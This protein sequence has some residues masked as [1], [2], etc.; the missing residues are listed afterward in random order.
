MS[1][2]ATQTPPLTTGNDAAVEPPPYRNPADDLALITNAT[3]QGL[4]CSGN[5]AFAHLI[6]SNMRSAE[7]YTNLVR[8]YLRLAEYC[9]YVVKMHS[10]IRA[11][12][13]D[14]QLQ[15]YP[16]FWPFDPDRASAEEA[17]GLYEY[18]AV[19]RK[20]PG[21]QCSLTELPSR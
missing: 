20:S 8:A 3:S 14:R 2:A 1:D 15:G 17:S 9:H 11:S 7:D 10:D 13:S 12:L 18:R 4:I 16:P 19:F 5:A 21:L 6:Q